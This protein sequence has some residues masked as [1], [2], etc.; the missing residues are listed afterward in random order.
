MSRPKPTAVIH[1]FFRDRPGRSLEEEFRAHVRETFRPETFPGLHP[2]PIPKDTPF[3]K[4]AP[5]DI[6]KGKRAPGDYVPCPMCQPNKFLSGFLVWFPSLQAIAVIG[7]CCADKE[8]LAAADREYKERIAREQQEDFLLAEL[9]LVP[10][11]LAVIQQARPGAEHALHLHR[12]FK[13]NGAP[14]FRMLQEVNRAGGYLRLAYEAE[15]RTAG[16]GPSGYRGG[17]N[18]SV[19]FR[20]F[21]RL[22]GSTALLSTYNPLQELDQAYRWLAHYTGKATEEEALEYIV[23]LSPQDRKM[24]AGHIASATAAFARYQQRL[25]DFGSFFSPAN[26]DRVAAWASAP[27]QRDQFEVEHG[28][29]AEQMVLTMRSGLGFLRLT[30]RTARW[31]PLTWPE[32]PST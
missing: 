25:A 9:P 1:T 23:G 10:S 29:T 4:L 11:R 8:V 21:G 20:E 27:E 3:F 15:V 24:A 19:T 18:P 17:D 6:D 22:D 30:V 13:K 12:L 14:F 16:V 26:L 32:V 7:H 2:G 28:G 31:L 5:V